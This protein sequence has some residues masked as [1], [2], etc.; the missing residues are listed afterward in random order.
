MIVISPSR[1]E[2]GAFK[3]KHDV[4]TT[5]RT[6]IGADRIVGCCGYLGGVRFT[7]TGRTVEWFISI[8]MV[9]LGLQ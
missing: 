7:F 2:V 1:D 6:F 4:K 5:P 9:L 8:S 3:A